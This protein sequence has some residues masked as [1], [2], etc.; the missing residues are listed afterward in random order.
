MSQSDSCDYFKNFFKKVESL[1]GDEI[2]QKK[3]ELCESFNHFLDD[4]AEKKEQ[5]EKKEQKKSQKKKS[6][7]KENQEKKLGAYIKFQMDYNGCLGKFS[8]K[9]KSGPELS[10]EYYNYKK[11]SDEEKKNY[12]DVLEK[13][14][15]KKRKKLKKK[16]KRKK[17]KKK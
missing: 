14:L 6:E 15:E 17:L 16:K 10:S 7:K 2:R 13:D 4:Y 8:F 5:P 11:L 1:S 3:Q 9:K 12:W